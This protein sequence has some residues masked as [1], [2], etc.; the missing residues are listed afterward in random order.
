MFLQPSIQAE[1][2]GTVRIFTYD[3]S[4][5]SLISQFDI[6]LEKSRFAELIPVVMYAGLQT[7]KDTDGLTLNQLSDI[8]GVLFQMKQADI[9]KVF[10]HGIKAL[11]FINQTAEL[12][13]GL[14]VDEEKQLN[15]P[16]VSKPKSIKPTQ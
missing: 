12:A 15:L 13:L 6:D 14:L 9:A 8:S 1:V 16:K 10:A 4:T 5:L 3:Y 2:G 11:G 7:S